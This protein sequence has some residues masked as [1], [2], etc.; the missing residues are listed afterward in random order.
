LADSPSLT[1][2]EI[3][4]LLKRADRG[5][6]C[7][8]ALGDA[9]LAAAAV[10]VDVAEAGDVT[11]ALETVRQAHEWLLAESRANHDIHGTERRPWP[12]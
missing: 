4:C 11:T 8:I 9:G 1:Q 7:F 5:V 10:V 2:H 3:H 6:D 12:A